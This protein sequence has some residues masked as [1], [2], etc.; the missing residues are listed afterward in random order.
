MGCGVS[1]SHFSRISFTVCGIV[2]DSRRLQSVGGDGPSQGCR[3]AVWPVR[4]VAWFLHRAVR[5][6]A[7][8]A[9][10]LSSPL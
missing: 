10:S 7:G 2:L 6:A 4:G 8:A 1:D 3:C 5:V 9:F